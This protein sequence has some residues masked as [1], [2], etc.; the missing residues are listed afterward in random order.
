MLSLALSKEQGFKISL[1]EIERQGKSYTIDTL[2]EF[3]KKEPETKFYFIIGSDMLFY[4]EQWKDFKEIFKLCTIVALSRLKKDEQRAIV[5]KNTLAEKYGADIIVLKNEIREI[6]STEIRK[7]V[8]NGEDFSRDVPEMVRDYIE[9]NHIYDERYDFESLSKKIR[10]MTT[11][12]RFRHIESTIKEAVELAKRFGA[13]E[14]KARLAALLHDSTKNLGEAEQYALMEKYGLSF[15]QWTK[16]EPKLF[17]AVTGAVFAKEELLIEDEEILSAIR[18]HT[19]GKADMT[20]LEKII[21][22]AD[23]IEETRKEFPDLKKIREVSKVDLS[24]AVL[25][26]RY[27]S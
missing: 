24:E 12:K 13:N 8:R 11:E 25:L 18:Y 7:K 1:D 16:K 10:E 14:K 27:S 9:K 22:L 19:T 2:R 5:H 20:L 3:H 6:S 15:D 26:A 4:F 21:Y 23:M 17:H